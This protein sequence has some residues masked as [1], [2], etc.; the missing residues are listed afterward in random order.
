[1]KPLV[2]TSIAGLLMSLYLTYLDL[3]FAALAGLSSL[4]SASSFF[5]CDAVR[6][7]PYAHLFNV[8]LALYGLVWFTSM[9]GISISLS[10]SASGGR[11]LWVFNNELFTA[12][13]IWLFIG[14]LSVFY[15]WFAE[16]VIGAICPLCTFVHGVIIVQCVL[17]YR[18]YVQRKRLNASARLSTD[19]GAIVFAARRWLILAALLSILFIVLCNTGSLPTEGA[20]EWDLGSDN[21]NDAK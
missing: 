5:S 15:F 10:R 14:L 18:L 1:M 8:P 13:L 16:F 17:A 9:L 21:F 12:Q 11:L 4:C 6:A 2:Y 7:S 20:R 19:F 3:G